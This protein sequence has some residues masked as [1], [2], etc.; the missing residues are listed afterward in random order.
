MV[1]IV[2]DGVWAPDVAPNT[3]SQTSGVA[4]D[5]QGVDTDVSE[6]VVRVKS[7]AAAGQAATLSVETSR[8]RLPNLTPERAQATQR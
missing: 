3:S 5:R 7:S 1:G 8:T 2:T 6:T 4:S